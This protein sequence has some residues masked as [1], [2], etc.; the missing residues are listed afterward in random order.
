MRARNTG[1][2]EHEGQDSSCMQ[3]APSAPMARSLAWWSSLPAR[4]TRLELQVPLTET[5]TQLVMFSLFISRPRHGRSRCRCTDS[6]RSP[7]APR[8]RQTWRST[9]W[10][11]SAPESP[12]LP[13]GPAPLRQSDAR[14]S[15]AVAPGPARPIT[16]RAT[17]PPLPRTSCS[18][19]SIYF[20]PRA[21]PMSVPAGTRSPHRPI[22]AQGNRSRPL[23]A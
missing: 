23:S 11:T 5:S 4:W 19:A 9:S 22:R 8:P 21:L 12:S 2:I 20:I 3:E 17:P 1:W 16:W 14:A 15:L 13:H 18:T 7:G 10:A 6:A